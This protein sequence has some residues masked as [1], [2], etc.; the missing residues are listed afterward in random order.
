M[1]KVEYVDYQEGN[2]SIMINEHYLSPTTT[3]SP[4]KV[5][6]ANLALRRLG[7]PKQPI[8]VRCQKGIPIRRDYFAG[9]QK[10]F[11]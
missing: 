6:D 9:V 8:R 2:E 5:I 4:K 10:R 3:K 11:K 7:I 1:D